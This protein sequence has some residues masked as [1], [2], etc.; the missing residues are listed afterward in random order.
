MLAGVAAGVA[1]T[2]DADPSLVRIL[3]ALLAILTGGI[4]LL[5]YIVMAIVVP[6]APD[7]RELAAPHSPSTTP[8]APDA[9]VPAAA[10]VPQSSAAM[11]TRP[12]RRAA[13]RARRREAIGSGEAG[14]IFG[15]VLIVIGGLF[16]ARQV[17]PWF[18]FH[19]W[20][21]IGIVALGVL[22]IVV[23][24]RPGRPTE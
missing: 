19:L 5:V 12:E 1:E 18:G 24:V 3:W 15:V 22:L 21:P 17:M 6:E 9:P 16:L 20:W 4:G 23:A 2:L 11:P 7:E 10:P 14:L 8:P 13:R